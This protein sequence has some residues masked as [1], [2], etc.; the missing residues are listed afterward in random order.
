MKGPVIGPDSS[1]DRVLY[2]IANLI[3]H[4]VGEPL[5][6]NRE[7]TVLVGLLEHGD[8]FLPISVSL[9]DEV[10]CVSG[11]ALQ[12]KVLWFELG[13]VNLCV[14][15]FT[16]H[17]IDASS[18]KLVHGFIGTLFKHAYEAWVDAHRFE[19]VDLWLSFGE[20]IE[21]PPI[22]SAVTLAKSLFNKAKNNFIRDRCTTLGC[23]L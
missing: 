17:W 3:E 5:C 10:L 22:D 2:G 12:S 19:Q 13:W 8:I 15:E 7:Q 21:N 1:V 14:E 6:A 16:S 20:A 23:L 4:L 11:H 18:L 9:A